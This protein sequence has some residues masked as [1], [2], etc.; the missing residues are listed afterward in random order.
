MNFGALGSGGDELK[1]LESEFL[2]AHADCWTARQAP[3]FSV[4][5]VH[6]MEIPA[7]PARI[8]PELAAQD[9]LAPGLFWKFL[10]GFR[11][12]IGKLFG[13]DQGMAVN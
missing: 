12:A 9:L 2:A 6:A 3:E 13:W 1:I 7:P 8:F 10:L 4:L 11:I 5:D